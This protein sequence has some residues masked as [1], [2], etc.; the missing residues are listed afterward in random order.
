VASA[1][2]VMP[3]FGLGARPEHLGGKAGVTAPNPVPMEGSVV[4]EMPP[5]V[6]P[7]SGEEWVAKLV[8]HVATMNERHA[9]VLMGGKNRIMRRKVSKLKE[10]EPLYEFYAAR[11]L[12]MMYVNTLIQ[13][14]W[15]EVR[16]EKKAIY[17]DHL[18]AW[19]KHKDC[20]T[21]LEGVKFEPHPHGTANPCGEGQFNLWAGFDVEPCAGDW[22]LLDHHIHNVMCEA[23]PE[24]YEYVMNWMA[25]KIQNPAKL[26]KAALVCRGKK[27]SGKGTLG[28]FLRKVFGEHGLHVTNGEHF[29]GKF[30]AH[31]AEKVFLFADEAF[32][33]NDKK[34]EG[35]LKALITDETMMVERKGL[36]AEQQTNY[37]AVFMS[38]NEDWAVP[39]TED[40]RR[41]CVLDV[42]SKYLKDESYFVPLYA[43]LDKP[44]T[45]AA[46]LHTMLNRDVKGWN[47]SKIP[48]TKGLQDQRL[49]SLDSVGKWLVDS[50]SNGGF[51]L[52]A[53][54]YEIRGWTETVRA[55]LLIASYSD[56]CK[57]HS[58][59]TYDRKTDTAVGIALGKVFGK[60][61][62]TRDGNV[63]TLG[64]LEQ[65]AQTV[66]DFYKLGDVF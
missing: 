39:A 57:E 28:H 31:L 52:S 49:H 19:L 7:P 25:Y 45:T 61:H 62:H 9:N 55:K 40:E 48:E 21:Y 27:G 29:I 51:G 15:R 53:D 32:F 23:N 41:Y 35:V 10:F 38:T 34:H 59:S 50:L 66:K 13:T 16:G 24:L 60:R 58:V 2:G 47:P 11:E 42:S 46:F 12:E 26:P 3:A 37:M 54:Q 1:A 8:A 63:Y 44:E 5:L 18:N 56:Y 6:A 33:S 43:Q 14:G 36:D 20:R 4:G 30:N 22:S 65:A 17:R 64:T